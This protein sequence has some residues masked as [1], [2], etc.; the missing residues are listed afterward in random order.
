MSTV[1]NADAY[2]QIEQWDAVVPR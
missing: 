1:I 2:K